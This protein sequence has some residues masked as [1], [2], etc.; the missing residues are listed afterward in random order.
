MGNTPGH[1]SQ[2]FEPLC[3]LH[4]LFEQMTFM[5]R[6]KMV[7]RGKCLRRLVCQFRGELQFVGKPTTNAAMMLVAKN[8][9]KFT[10]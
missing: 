4:A 1:D 7:L 6:A 8:T 9:G 3:L 2:A 10:A 5:F